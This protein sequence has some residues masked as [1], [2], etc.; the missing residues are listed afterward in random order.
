[1]SK[2]PQSSQP[3]AERKTDVGGYDASLPRDRLRP[4]LAILNT[5]IALVFVS[6]FGS[7]IASGAGISKDSRSEAASSSKLGDHRRAAVGHKTQAQGVKLLQVAR[8]KNPLYVTAPPGDRWR[9]FVVEKGGRIWVVRGGK[10]LRTPFLNISKQTSDGF[11]QGLLSMAFSPDYRDSGTFY[12]NYTDNN[13]NTRIEEYRRATSDRADPRSARLVLSV[14][15]PSPIHNGGL[16]TF[17][18]DGLLYIGLGDGGGGG[19]PNRNGQNLGTLLGKILRIDPRAQD[20]LPYTVPPSN[21]FLRRPGALPE[22]YAYGLRNPWRFSFDSKNGNL[23]IGDVGQNTVEEINFVGRAQGEAANFGWS[24]WEGDRRFRIDETAP[25]HIPPILVRNHKA[26]W[27]S[28]I[29]GLVVR[30]DR[31]KGLRGRYIFGD[32]C[33]GQIFGALLTRPKASQIRNTRLRVSSLTSFGVDA[34]N[35]I[36]AASLEGPVYRLVPR[37]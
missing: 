17:G 8:F 21:P 18:P 4:I 31:L 14:E 10:K 6:A 25:G 16:V 28:I 22:I 29:A 24:A 27:C 12:I 23:T 13:G 19:D 3:I 36:Y 15:Q 37:R 26:G 1:M 34:R 2:S 30:D 5:A 33:K 20:G 11:E 32:L 7:A 9:V 35:R